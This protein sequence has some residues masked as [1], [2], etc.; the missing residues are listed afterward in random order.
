M[1]MGIG[2]PNGSNPVDASQRGTVHKWQ[3]NQQNFQALAVALQ[4]G[5][6]AGAQTAFSALAT[7]K[8]DFASVLAASGGPQAGAG[9]GGSSAAMTQLGQAL[10]SGNLS[11]AQAAFQTLASNRS[12]HH[13]HHHGGAGSTIAS[14]ASNATSAP[15]TAGSAQLINALA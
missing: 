5:D 15:S 4:N 1:V 10:G 7:N 12:H 14:A 9:T 3:Q 8:P 13:H 2:V 6:L 11:Q